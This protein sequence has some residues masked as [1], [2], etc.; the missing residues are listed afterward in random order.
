MSIKAYENSDFLHSLEARNLRI[1]SEYQYPASEF[2][3][4]KVLGTVV[5]FG[6]ARIHDRVEQELEIKRLRDANASG[7]TIEYAE[8]KL[9]LC[10]FYD[11]AVELSRLITLWGQEI[12]KNDN[13]RLVV[14]TG[15]GPGIM[16]AGNRGASEAGGES[17][18]LNISLPFEQVPNSYVTTELSFEFHY[19]FMRKFWFLNLS[20]ALVVFPGGFG[21]IDELFETLTLIQTGKTTE[22]L[23]VVLYGSG[24]WK[25]LINFDLLMDNGLIAPGDMDLMHFVDTPEEAMK[26]LR[27][28]IVL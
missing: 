12:S 26:I 18:A 16:E 5:M 10:R 7:V 24:F 4:K 14:C 3:K 15:G 19:F 20:K 28:H 1:L 11:E 6:S 22:K 27:S 23:P 8:K 25:D 21:T 13:R 17:V 9:K 2:E